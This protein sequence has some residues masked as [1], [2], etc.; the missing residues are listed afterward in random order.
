MY[1]SCTKEGGWCFKESWQSKAR[2]Y[3]AQSCHQNFKKVSFVASLIVVVICS[4]LIVRCSCRNGAG[5]GAYKV[6]INVAI[7]LKEEDPVGD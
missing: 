7:Y 2:G 6:I 3:Q 4:I 5:S 1:E